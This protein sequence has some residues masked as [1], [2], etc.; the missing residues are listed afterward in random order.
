MAVNT[1]D[2]AVSTDYNDAG[3][4][5]TT[6]E[7]DRVPTSADDV[8]I[9]D[10]SSINN[11]ELSATGGNPKNV[12]SLELQ[13]NGTLI[14]NDISIRAYGENGSGRAID[15]DGII[16]GDLS[17]T[18]QTNAATNVDLVPSSGTIKNLTINHADCVA[19]LLH[20][21]SISGNLTITLGELACQTGGSGRTL[22]VAGNTRIGPASGGA[23]Q[24]TLTALDQDLLL[25]SGKTDD[26]GLTVVKGGT[27]VG[28]TGTHTIG[29]INMADFGDAKCTLTSGVTTI[30][31]EDSGDDY[32]INIGGDS[33]FAHGSGTVTLTRASDTRIRNSGAVLALNNLIINHA[34]ASYTLASNGLTCA[35]NLTITAGT[36]STGVNKPL[37]VTGLCNIGGGI[38]TG[39]ASA[40]SLGGLLVGSAGKYNA[41]SGTT[42]ITAEDTTGYAWDV[43][44][45]DSFDNNDGGVTF[46]LGSGVDSHIR[47]GQSDGANSFH[48]LTVLL[49]AS[50]NTLTMRPNAGTVM[51]IEGNLTISEGVL[52]KNTHSHNLTVTGNV[53]IHSGGKIDATSASGAM[54]MGSLSIDA[55]GTYLATGGTTTITSEG[56]GSSGTNGYALMAPT[57]AIFTHNGGTVSIDTDATTVIY[58]QSATNT[59]N[60]LIINNNGNRTQWDGTLTILG[61]LTVNASDTFQAD[62]AN[63]GLTVN[64]NVSV[65]GT[66][67]FASMAWAGAGEFGSLTIATGGTYLAT[68]GTTTITNETG[69]HAWK[70]NGGTF[71]HNNGKVLIDFDTDNLAGDTEVKENTFY[72]LE[73]K[74]DQA[75]YELRLEDHSSTNAMDILN[76]LTVT[77]GTFDTMTK[78]DTLTIHGQT[79]IESDGVFTEAD[80]DTNKIIHNGIVRNSGTYKINDG[81]TVKMNSGIRNL[82][83][84]TVA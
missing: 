64:G 33:T 83:T 11:C 27:F 80:H 4:W 60:D 37:T 20:N 82:G 29:S 79:I 74:L 62:G 9:P 84:I 59:F 56:D 19:N 67:G 63:N 21:T 77:K 51:T 5:N 18:I 23:D 15:L 16:S 41:T 53:E 28:G 35:G 3:N 44:G 48:N 43:N 34:S 25:G 71:T 49:N 73:I 76:N 75:G 46:D 22:T 47:T 14:G 40:I 68:S 38:L 58:I 65:S 1:W 2:G 17:L 52:Q 55:G 50:T 7:T 32:A 36:F 45:T 70:N 57:G 10:T 61:D 30:N 81:T 12:K 54:N 26:Y 72:D 42:T 66:L 24:A 78:S 69:G 39:N 8:V 13:A 31:G 6:G